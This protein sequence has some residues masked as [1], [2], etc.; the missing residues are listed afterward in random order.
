MTDDKKIMICLDVKFLNNHGV[1]R[2]AKDTSENP[3]DELY[4]NP[5]LKPIV[6]VE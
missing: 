6:N 4:A 2:E 1:Q 3:F 5:T